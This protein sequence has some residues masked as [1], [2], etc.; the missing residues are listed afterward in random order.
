M[1]VLSR[2]MLVIAL[3]FSANALHAQLNFDG[4]YCPGPG[5]AGDE[6]AAAMN[7][8]FTP[9]SS[10]TCNLFEIY[11]IL[12]KTDINN[13]EIILGIEHGNGGQALFRF[14]FNTDCDA[15][16]GS[17]M[18]P[19]RQNQAALASVG[20]AD[21][22]VDISGNGGSATVYEIGSVNGDGTGNWNDITS[23]TSGFNALAGVVDTDGTCNGSSSFIELA[24]PIDL[25]F[26]PCMPT[27]CGAIELTAA[28]SNAGNSP[29]S[30]FCQ[31]ESISVAI[32]INKPPIA[33]FTIPSEVCQNFDGSFDPIDLDA[34]ATLDSDILNNGDAL[35]YVWSSDNTGS[36]SNLS[37]LAVTSMAD[38]STVYTPG[39]VGIHTI[40]LQVTD[41]FGCTA[42]TDD[43]AVYQVEVFSNQV[44]VCATLPIELTSF[45]GK[46]ASNGIAQLSWTTASETNNDYFEVQRRHESGDWE[47]VGSLP[48]AGTTSQSQSYEISD[49]LPGTSGTYYYRLK[50]VDTDGVYT[51]SNVIL[52]KFKVDKDEAF[53][54]HNPDGSLAVNVELVDGA[55]IEKITVYDILG[56][57]VRQL[58]VNERSFGFS[59]YILNTESMRTGTYIVTIV[60]DSKTITSKTIIAK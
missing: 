58:N 47:V 60:T 39:A 17:L 20:G 50:Q 10:S 53:V 38:I 55:I 5:V 43:T 46:I 45:K 28:L 36:F 27:T 12:D 33:D 15:T 26:D 37:G 56:R 44:Q 1:N 41:Q 11:A 6:L 16:T 19:E 51:F 4:N 35:D 32:P 49:I 21:F 8:S 48:G 34:S 30:Q 9:G 52:L 13:S 25:L 23:S 42:A 29:T 7:V 2:L 59:Q 57:P 22:R 24:V 31:S 40:T 3:A 54:I 14:F 18:E